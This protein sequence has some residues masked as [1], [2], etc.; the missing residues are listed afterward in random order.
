MRVEP[1]GG[2][3]RGVWYLRHDAREIRPKEPGCVS[4]VVAKELGTYDHESKRAC[5]HR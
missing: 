2:R 5:M 3:T 4:L 1:S